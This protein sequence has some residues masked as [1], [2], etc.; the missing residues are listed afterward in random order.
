MAASQ[1][2]TPQPIYPYDLNLAMDRVYNRITTYFDARFDKVMTEIRVLQADIAEVKE[3]EQRQNDRMT[4]LASFQ[5]TM[6]DASKA[7]TA[8]LLQII[9]DLHAEAMEAINEL[10]PKGNE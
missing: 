5:R 9:R 7:Q 8:D 4:A 1:Q 2:P 6:M 3:E 10:H